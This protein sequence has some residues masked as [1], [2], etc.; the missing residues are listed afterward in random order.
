MKCDSEVT[1]LARTRLR[2]RQVDASHRH[3]RLPP[4]QGAAGRLRRR[5]IV[6]RGRRAGEL[7]LDEEKVRPGMLDRAEEVAHRGDLLDL[8]LQEPLH[9]LL[10]QVVALLARELRELGALLGDA[11]L[12][13]ERETDGRGRLGELGASV[14]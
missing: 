7:V 4:L 5:R 2:T 6:S 13:L 14:R 9:E 10:A 1:E 8:L 11:L 3:Y 12:L